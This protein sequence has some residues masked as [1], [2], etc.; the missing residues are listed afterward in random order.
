MRDNLAVKDSNRRET[1]VQVAFERLASHGFEGLRLRGI[2]EAAGIDHSTLHHYFPT[3]QHLIE[4]VA[5]FATRR[6]RGTPPATGTLETHLRAHLA[7]QAR[8]IGEHPEL[9]NVLRELDL[10]AT[11]DPAVAAVIARSDA[12]WR[13]SLLPLLTGKP[14]IEPGA[15]AD[16]IIATIKGLSFNSARANAVLGQLDMLLSNRDM[17]R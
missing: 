9:F 8:M 16:L 13:S 5:D 7:T 1:L 4:S 12:A 14:G 6:F 17:R 3:R 11:R 15:A 2:A 10:R